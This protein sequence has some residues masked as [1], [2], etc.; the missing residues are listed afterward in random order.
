MARCRQ[1]N[2]AR[3]RVASR[4]RRWASPTGDCPSVAAA[5]A[6]APAR[7]VGVSNSARRE[8]LRRTPRHARSRG[9]FQGSPWYRSRGSRGPLPSG[10]DRPRR[11]PANA[12]NTR[13]RAAGVV[14]KKQF[15]RIHG[16]QIIACLIIA[17]AIPARLPQ[18]L[19]V[20][21]RQLVGFGLHQ[22]VRHEPCSLFSASGWADSGLTCGHLANCTDSWLGG[23]CRPFDPQ[24]PRA[25]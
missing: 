25:R 13:F 4:P 6:P 18:A 16:A 21:D 17:H 19:Q 5:S 22:P 3:V 11:D 20:V 14:E 15:A 8:R 9:S 1:L 12:G 2:A 23:K 10:R 24:R 7:R